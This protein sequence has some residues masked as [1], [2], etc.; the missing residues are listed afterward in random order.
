LCLAV[1]AGLAPVRATALACRAGSGP[2][3]GELAAAADAALAGV[4]LSAP[5]GP[6]VRGAPS[7]GQAP[8]GGRRRPGESPA[9]GAFPRP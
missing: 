8:A 4:P 6:R 5:A 3:S 1:T 7:F 2:L 9:R